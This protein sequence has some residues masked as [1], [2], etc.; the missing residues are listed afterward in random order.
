MKNQDYHSSITVN[1]PAAQ[2]FDNI[3]NVAGWWTE[4]IEGGSKKLND[5]FTVYFGETFVTFKIIEVIPKKKI[6]W[7]VTDCDLPWLNDKKEWKNTEVVWEI[8][9]HNNSTQIDMTHV[10]L[11]PE[12]NVTIVAKKDGMNM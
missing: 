12:L 2:A 1:M 3:C 8:S 5:V 7:L 11:T 4:N 9:T 6:V 10:G